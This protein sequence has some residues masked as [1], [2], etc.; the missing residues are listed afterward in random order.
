M[1]KWNDSLNIGVESIDND[2]KKLLI[3]INKFFNE[4]N[5]NNYEKI[6]D[7]LTLRT[8]HQLKFLKSDLIGTN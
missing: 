7:E 4:K 5:L 6:F 3:I 8:L 2:H 1:I